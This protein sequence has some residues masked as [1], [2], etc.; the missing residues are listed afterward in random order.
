M[1]DALRK[2]TSPT[3]ANAIETF[4]LVDFGL[5]VKVDGSHDRT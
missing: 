1:I 2:I 4:K 5:P 3:V